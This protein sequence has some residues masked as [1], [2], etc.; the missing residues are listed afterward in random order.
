MNIK[1]LNEELFV[2]DIIRF[3]KN[4]NRLKLKNYSLDYAPIYK[5]VEKELK[6]IKKIQKSSTIKLLIIPAKSSFVNSD[7]YF[8]FKVKEY[9]SK[10]NS[11]T[12][13]YI[14]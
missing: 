14:N 11:I 8:F 12:L 10:S 2:K 9:N 4:R 13:Q 6:N 5:K 1:I 7:C 3:I